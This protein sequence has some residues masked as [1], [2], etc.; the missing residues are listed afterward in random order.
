MFNTLGL[1]LYGSHSHFSDAK[2][3]FFCLE[4]KWELQKQVGAHILAYTDH[5]M[6][7][8]YMPKQPVEGGTW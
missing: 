8:K 6:I 3:I 4:E 2:L 7:A 5:P 1:I